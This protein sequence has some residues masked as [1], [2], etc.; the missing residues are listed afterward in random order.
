MRSDYTISR[1][2]S[3]VISLTYKTFEIS[4]FSCSN[5]IQFKEIRQKLAV[6]FAVFD[7]GVGVKADGEGERGQ[8]VSVR[9]KGKRLTYIFHIEGSFKRRYKIPSLKNHWLAMFQII[10]KTV[11][12]TSQN[13]C[14]VR[15]GS[16]KQNILLI[17][18]TT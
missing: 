16:K 13:G 6:N 1:L 12:E 7:S 5:W 10:S 2:L 14:Q 11:N 9:F 8:N 15:L 4:S 18:N 17:A 3:V